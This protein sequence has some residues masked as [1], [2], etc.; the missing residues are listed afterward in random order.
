MPQFPSV[1]PWWWIGLTSAVA[2]I[3][4]FGLI[5]FLYKEFSISEVWL[6]ALVVGLSVLAWRLAGNIPELNDDPLPPFSPNDLLC[7]VIT[8]IFLSIY[9]TFRTNLKRN[10]SYFERA[11][12][13]LTIISLVVNVLVI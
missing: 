12:A 8:Y 3:V 5:R 2:L 7:P 9:A 11:R 13:L 6:L 1:F 10:E 4:S